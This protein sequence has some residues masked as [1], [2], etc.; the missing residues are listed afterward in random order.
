M[1]DPSLHNLY[2]DPN[3]PGYW[4]HSMVPIP[5]IK[6][7]NLPKIADTAQNKKLNVN[8]NKKVTRCPN[9]TRPND[10]CKC[11]FAQGS[12]VNS[13]NASDLPLPK[14]F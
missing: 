3:N 4:I 9:C 13:P 8:G 11:K 1:S 6:T 10:K 7:K 14:N 2:P 12:Y 5:Q